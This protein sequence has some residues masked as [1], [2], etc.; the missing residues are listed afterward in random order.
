MIEMNQID[1]FSRV[2]MC[3][4]LCA[5]IHIHTT[6][7]LLN[8]KKMSHGF[9][10]SIFNWNELLTT[11]H[12]REFSDWKKIPTKWCRRSLYSWKYWC[13]SHANLIV[14]ITVIIRSQLFSLSGKGRSSISLT[15]GLSNRKFSFIS[16]FKVYWT[17]TI[18]HYSS[19]D[20]H[21]FLR[22][23]AYKTQTHTQIFNLAPS[24]RFKCYILYRI[25]FKMNTKLFSENLME[26]KYTVP[27]K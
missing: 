21:L 4:H 15:R 25:K 8:H 24:D 23:S 10:C 16:D 6:W 14:A 5:H 26:T 18:W 20:F 3:T 22:N 13:S 19:C 12:K 7:I 27:S 1:L 11:K 9:F 2:R 17:Q